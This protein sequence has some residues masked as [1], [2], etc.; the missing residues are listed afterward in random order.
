VPD[1]R[2]RFEPIER[3]TVSEGIRDALLESIRSGAL[4]PGSRLPS[5][6]S[7]CEEFGVARTSV[8]EAIQGLVS[9]GVITK[10]ANRPY[11]AEQLPGMEFAGHADRKRYLEEL[12]EVRRVVEVPI[13]R[14]A[15]TRAATADRVQI[16]AIARRLSPEMSLADFRRTARAF[17]VAIARACGNETLAELYGKV[18]DAQ[19]NS[20]VLDSLLDSSSNLWLVKQVIFDS[21]KTYLE[22][23]DAIFEGNADRAIAAVERHLSQVEQ[24]LIARIV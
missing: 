21:A 7:L 24:Q 22:I 3:Q 4:L 5:E 12:V 1:V 19:F 2:P 14:L 8:R 23:A 15:A 13:A 18:L 11:V 17:H 20:S 9:I 16:R 6:R 10:R